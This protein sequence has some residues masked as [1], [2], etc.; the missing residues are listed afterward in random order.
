M[1]SDIP[2]TN[3]ITSF[4]HCVRCI[5]EIKG[6]GAPDPTDEA[7]NLSPGEF[8]RFEVGW[9]AWGF[10]VWCTRHDCNVLHVDFE[11]EQHPANTTRPAPKKLKRI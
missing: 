2:N 10:Q 8:A 4:I 6:G 11:D 7:V 5:D 1:A 9:T 3:E